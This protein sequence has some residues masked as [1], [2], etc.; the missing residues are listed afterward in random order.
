M[1]MEE[2]HLD[3]HIVWILIQFNWAN[4]NLIKPTEVKGCPSE[5]SYVRLR[6]SLGYFIV[7]N[8]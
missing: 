2:R 1:R 3:N 5:V 8:S 7:L 4:H 6:E